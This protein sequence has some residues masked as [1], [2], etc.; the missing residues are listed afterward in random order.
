ML[1][2]KYWVLLISLQKVIFAKKLISKQK[3]QKLKIKELNFSLCKNKTPDF[4][5]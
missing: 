4:D 1:I 5:T 3:S 2:R